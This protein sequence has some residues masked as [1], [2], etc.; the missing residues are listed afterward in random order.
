MK[1][2]FE[3][4]FENNILCYLS[5]REFRFINAMSKIAKIV[6]DSISS[7]KYGKF[8]TETEKELKES[9][10]ICKDYKMDCDAVINLEKY[11]FKPKNSSI[12]TYN[13]PEW[14]NFPNVIGKCLNDLPERGFVY[15]AWRTNPLLVYYVGKTE[16]SDGERILKLKKHNSLS[17]AIE[18]GAKLFTIIFP[19]NSNNIGS[20]EGSFIRIIKKLGKGNE[21]L[22][23][24]DE[25]FD[26][27]KDGELL[28]LEKF[29]DK[30]NKMVKAYNK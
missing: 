18:K 11:V 24:K 22:N 25:P 7:R 14:K 8:H 20:V 27:W 12:T 6:K 3:E 29:F 21:M 13:C 26:T 10:D 5:N 30:M 15:I 23:E 19:D 28:K 9:L 16:C 2:L 17:R 1:D 4:K